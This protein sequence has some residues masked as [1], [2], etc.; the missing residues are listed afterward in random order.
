MA[1]ITDS[2]RAELL[3]RSKFRSRFK[4]DPKD[5]EYIERVGLAAVERHAEDFIR[6]RLAPAHPAKDG[7][8][9]PFKGHPVFKAQH[10]TATC[11]RQC[12]EK[13]YGIPRGRE[14]TPSEIRIITRAIMGWIGD[15]RTGRGER[16]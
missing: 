1:A 11:C 14:L 12:L 9:T 3:A 15:G 6:E 5:L 8:Q 16:F 4:L 2:N 7:K 13:W 10:A